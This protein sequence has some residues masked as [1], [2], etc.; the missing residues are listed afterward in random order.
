MLKETFDDAD[1]CVLVK[2][3]KELS[4]GVNLINFNLSTIC[5]GCVGVS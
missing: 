2:G 5:C 1:V 4:I 3:R